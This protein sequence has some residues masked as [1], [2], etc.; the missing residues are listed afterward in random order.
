M[1]IEI[2]YSN[3]A[4]ESA[5]IP[6]DIEILSFMVG[7]YPRSI[8]YSDGRVLVYS[9]TANRKKPNVKFKGKQLYGAIALMKEA[10]YERIIHG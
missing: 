7:G 2:R 9:E 1:N 3:G 6:E 10:D 4:R 5:N 8:P